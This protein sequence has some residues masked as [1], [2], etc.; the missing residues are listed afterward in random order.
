MPA[1]TGDLHV[2]AS[3]TPRGK[4]V[5]GFLPPRE[6]DAWR[7]GHPDI[8]AFRDLM[9]R[10]RVVG[11]V[12]FAAQP[13]IAYRIDAPPDASPFVILDV[14]KSFWQTFFSG[15]PGWIGIGSE[16][17]GDVILST[18]PVRPPQTSE[19]C[20]GER[21]QLI[22][23]H[24]PDVAG[25]IGN[26]TERRF[27]AYLPPSYRGSATRRYP[28][29]F[30][31]GGFMSNEMAR[32]RGSHHAGDMA[33]ALA[34]ETGSEAILVGVDAST[35]IGSSYLEDSPVTGKWDTFIT[36]QA[37]LT[38]DKQLRTIPKR[39]ARGIIGQST[40]GFIAISFGMKHS[41]RF[42]AIAATAPDGLDMRAWLFGDAETAKPWIL[43]W[44]RMEDSLGGPGQMNSYAADWSPGKD[45]QYEWPYDL[46][47]GKPTAT[48]ASWVAHSPAGMLDDPAVLERV[49]QHLAGRILLAISEHDEFDLTEPARIFSKKLR[50]L[51]IDHELEV[52]AAGHLAGID[53]RTEKGLRF[54][55][56][57]LRS[58]TR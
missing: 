38:I 28:V 3:A 12:D 54:V 37:I 41:D 20:G 51:G 58:P 4:L 42:G 40:G 25:S 49:R 53:A 32:F 31:F 50:T 21:M 47:N 18:A 43:A 9:A 16:G 55:I 8:G 1:L 39:E 30:M 22:V 23:M 19:P 27:C 56:S 35:R 2:A 26:S 17:G 6:A 52:S 44:M 11:D 33:D 14:K 46:T 13:K 15:G 5:L 10:L 48:L 45:G 36:G 57:K 29:V 24:A 34:K 7:A